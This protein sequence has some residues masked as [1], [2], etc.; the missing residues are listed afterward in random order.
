MPSGMN[1]RPS[2]FSEL[3]EFYYEEYKPLY[4]HAQALNQLVV[5]ALFE[6]SAAFD[7]MSRHWKKGESEQACVER[8]ASHLKRGCLDAFKLVLKESRDHYDELRRIDTSIIDNGEFDRKLIALFAEIKAGAIE[9]RN[10]EGDTRNDAGWAIAFD[11]WKPVY[12]NCVRLEMEFYLNKNVEWAKRKQERLMWRRRFE[13]FL[14]G[15]L[16]SGTVAAIVAAL[17]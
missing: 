2:T 1:K 15:V 17:S 13:G 4:N 11:L 9:A 7:H 16:A 10:S 5:E 8:A 14:I 3:F 6:V 12:V